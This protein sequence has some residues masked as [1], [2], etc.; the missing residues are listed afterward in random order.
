MI[1]TYPCG[2]DGKTVL[3][4]DDEVGVCPRAE[5]ALGGLDAEGGGRVE[6]G[7][8]QTLNQ[9]ASEQG[10]KNKDLNSTATTT[11]TCRRCEK[12]IYLQTL[13]KSPCLRP[14]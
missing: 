10:I 2:L 4:K 12:Q 7:G 5:A 13:I 3:V 11:R 1:Q 6:G 14:S 8:L 9:A